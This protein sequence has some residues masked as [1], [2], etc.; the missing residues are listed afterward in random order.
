M[1]LSSEEDV[2]LLLRRIDEKMCTN[3]NR[4]R[5]L[6]ISYIKELPEWNDLIS[7]E[8][9]LV[10]LDYWKKYIKGN[11]I[12]AYASQLWADWNTITNPDVS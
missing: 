12:N 1:L 10:V 3:I 6:G 9:Y 11:R 5:S 8:N 7:K 2:Q 4:Y